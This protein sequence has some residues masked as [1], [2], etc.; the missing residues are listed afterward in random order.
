MNLKETEKEYIRCNSLMIPNPINVTLTLKKRYNNKN[1]DL[2]DIKRNT[3]HFLNRLHKKIFK[4]NRQNKC[5]K[6]I[7]IISESDRYHLH[8]ILQI[9]FRIR[10]EDYIELIK[11]CWSKTKWGYRESDFEIPRSIDREIGWSRYITNYKNFNVE[12]D[13]DNSIF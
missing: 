12:V 4:N 8:L 10:N 11:E 2:Y 6:R 3:K 5:L 13:Y 1:I 9:P 7:I